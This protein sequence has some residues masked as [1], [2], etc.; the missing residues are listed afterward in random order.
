MT[1]RRQ[2]FVR[3]AAATA[4][5]FV[6][7]LLLAAARQNSTPAPDLS[8]WSAVR[9]QFDLAP[10]WSHLSSFF[11]ASHP[12]PVREAIAAF[13]RAIDANPYLE[14]DHRGL[15][16]LLR[17]HAQVDVRAARHGHRLGPRRGVGEAAAD[18]SEL[19]ELR[20]VERVDGG[21][22]PGPAGDRAGSIARRLP[23][24]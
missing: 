7:D 22:A 4:A 3:G 1:S 19:F 24:F 13:R 5:A 21:E 6:P 8:T 15:R 10:G 12:R 9:A 14:V 16:L 18:D 17:G 23:R 2:F 11:L 20:G